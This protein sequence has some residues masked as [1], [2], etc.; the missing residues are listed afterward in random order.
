MVTESLTSLD[1]SS[2]TQK[3]CFLQ[4][5]ESAA[6]SIIPPITRCYLL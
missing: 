5:N 2:K 4:N 3:P 6:G 1:F